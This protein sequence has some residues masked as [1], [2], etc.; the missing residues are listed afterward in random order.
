MPDGTLN[1]ILLVEDDADVSLIAEVTLAEIGGFEVKT[2]ASAMEA[3]H[4][5]PA[6]APDLILMDVMM[7]EMDGISALE[8]FRREP[9]TAGTPVVLITARVQPG[10]LEH[11]AALGCG[12]IA[13]PFDPES[14]P[15]RLLE[16]WR[17]RRG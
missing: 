1:R 3:L 16:F 5:A 12:V 8:A 15:G 14:L 13:K 7:P 6:F 17:R 4:A 10:D 9:A 2:C 11:Y